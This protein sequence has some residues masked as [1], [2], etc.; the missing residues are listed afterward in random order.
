MT[1]AEQ[2]A[3]RIAERERELAK[4]QEGTA[5]LQLEARLARSDLR[6]VLDLGTSLVGIVRD[7]MGRAGGQIED[8]VRNVARDLNGD[9]G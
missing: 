5:M 4:L 7:V 9:R 8:S 3:E 6:M 1:E 2:G